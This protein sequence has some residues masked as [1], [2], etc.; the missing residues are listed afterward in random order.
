MKTALIL[1]IAILLGQARPPRNDPNGIWQAETGTRF[2]LRLTGSD[3]RVQLVEGS[4]PRFVKYEVN[5]K[6]TGE[7]NTYTGTGSFVAKM[8]N[9]KECRFDTEWQIIVVQAEKIAG[10]TSSVVPDPETCEVTGRTSI[11]IELQ[12]K[13]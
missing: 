10:F 5:L 1:A 4:N 2:E 7:V 13:N 6:N 12:K 9:G 3:L 11:M 8:Q